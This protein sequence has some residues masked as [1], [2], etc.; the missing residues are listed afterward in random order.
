METKM[1]YQGLRIFGTDFGMIATLLRDRNRRHVKLKYKRELKT[2]PGLVEMALARPLPIEDAMSITLD[3][4][5]STSAVATNLT[6][7]GSSK[8]NKSSGARVDKSRKAK[9]TRR[10]NRK[11]KSTSGVSDNDSGNDA[12]EEAPSS[13]IKVPG[14]VQPP[15]SSG[16]VGI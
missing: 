3:D 8:K 9:Q 13:L 11:S 10:K 2:M 6:S 12:A 14:V 5:K 7:L 16:A 1:F 4:G 15:I